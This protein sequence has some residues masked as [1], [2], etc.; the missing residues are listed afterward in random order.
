MTETFVEIKFS[1]KMNGC[2]LTVSVVE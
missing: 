2:H 1:Q